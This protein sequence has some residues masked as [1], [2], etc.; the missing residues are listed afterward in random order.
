[1]PYVFVFV[2]PG[3]PTTCIGKAILL[4]AS[5][6]SSSWLRGSSTTPTWL[7]S[8]PHALHSSPLFTDTSF[9]IKSIVSVPV[10]GSDAVKACRWMLSSIEKPKSVSDSASSTLSSIKNN[11][12]NVLLWWW[13]MR[14]AE[15]FHSQNMQKIMLQFIKQSIS[16]HLIRI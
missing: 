11:E 8:L 10:I 12:K 5:F 3:Q 9:S 16:I 13:L 2:I 1:M 4:F 6:F 7:F 15:M 14:C